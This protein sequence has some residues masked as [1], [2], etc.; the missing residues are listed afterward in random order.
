[1][2]SVQDLKNRETPA[3]FDEAKLGLFVT[4]NP[5]AIPAYAPLTSLAELQRDDPGDVKTLRR[6]PYAEMYQNTMGIPGSPTAR[7]HAERYG[8]MPYDGF[9]DQFR[10]EMIPRWSP[11]PLAELAAQMGARYVVMFTMTEDGFL[12]WPSGVPNPRKGARWQSTRDVIGELGDAIRGRG[13]RYGLAYSGGMDWTFARLPLRDDAQMTAATP[14]G[15]EYLAYADAHWE[16]LIDRYLPDVLWNDY[17]YPQGADVAGLLSRYFERVPEG[18]TNN[19]WDPDSYKDDLRPSSVYSDFVTPEYSIEDAPGLKWEACRGL[20]TS[21]GYN[22]EE[23][24]ATYMSSTELIH[25]FVD[26]VSRGGNLLINVGPTATG[27]IPWAQA[28]RLLALGWWLRVN[29]EAIY[30]TRPWVRHAGISGEGYGVR[31]TT[32]EDAVHA[33][34]LGTPRGPA[35]EIDVR[36]AD[37]AAASLAGVGGELPWAATPAGTRIELPEPLDRRSALSL[38]LSPANAVTPFDER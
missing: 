11:E 20:G 26:V 31:Y 35:V 32:G 28:Q 10:D 2:S 33:I 38:R 3:W 8:D 15:E 37:G 13:L 34:V 24:E 29:G 6:L 5:A 27:A 7:H 21:F 17:S 1:M 30:G 23:S 16:E 12:M 25:L 36:L 4:W 19:R 22:R 18:V 14:V 9:V